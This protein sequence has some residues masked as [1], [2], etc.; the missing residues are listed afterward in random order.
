[1]YHKIFVPLFITC[2]AGLMFFCSCGN[3]PV[4]KKERK[5]FAL[6]DSLLR[7]VNVTEVVVAPQKDAITLTVKVSFNDDV[8]IYVSR[9]FSLEHIHK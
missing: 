6:T 1:M 7:V 4:A 5:G 9:F 3:K 8:P 2:A